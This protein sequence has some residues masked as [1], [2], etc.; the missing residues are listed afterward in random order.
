[1]RTDL[2]LNLNL[3]PEHVVEAAGRCGFAGFEYFDFAED[4]TGLNALAQTPGYLPSHLVVRTFAATVHHPMPALLIFP[5][6]YSGLSCPISYVHLNYRIRPALIL[7]R[8]D[9]VNI[10]NLS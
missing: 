4:L 1:H 10:C 2:V 8:Q 6:Y 9:C 7:S 5:Q 3:P